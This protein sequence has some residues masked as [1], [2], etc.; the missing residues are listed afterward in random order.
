MA[1]VWRG[2]RRPRT[3]ASRAFGFIDGFDAKQRPC[4]LFKRDTPAFRGAAEAALEHIRTVLPQADGAGVDGRPFA[5][6]GTAAAGT[7]AGTTTFEGLGD[8]GE[9]LHRDGGMREMMQ[10][11]QRTIVAN[12]AAADEAMQLSLGLAEVS[13]CRPHP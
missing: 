4:L 9:Q 3:D 11:V 2:Q 10:Q 13:L 5:T 1:L 7:T 12:P 6:S 8:L